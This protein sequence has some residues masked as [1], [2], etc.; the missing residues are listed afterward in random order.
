MNKFWPTI[1]LALALVGCGPSRSELIFS[2]ASQKKETCKE[3][4][5]QKLFKTEVEFVQCSIQAE[6]RFSELENPDTDLL[7]LKY[8][9]SL[10][11]ASRKD[12]GA[13]TSE[14]LELE[15]AQIAS[16]V[17]SQAEQRFL[18]RRSVSAQE[19][20]ARAANQMA[21]PRAV[22]CIRSSTGVTCI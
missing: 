13:I 12:R 2:E 22:S 20:A 18:Q 8:A 14:Q 1:I 10:E 17:R 5:A 7:K 15:Y 3:R 4:K 19:S 6:S 11:A 9:A 21:A 16:N